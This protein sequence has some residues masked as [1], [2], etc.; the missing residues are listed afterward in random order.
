MA[1]RINFDAA[2]NPEV[3]TIILA[4][5]NGDKIGQLNAKSISISDAMNDASE[6]T[7]KVHKF[8]DGVKCKYWEQIVDFKLIYC[9]EWDMWF[10]ITIDLDESTDIQKTIFAV[11]LGNYELSQ[12]MLYEIE[13]N[14]ENDI[15]RDDYEL[16][17]VFYNTQNPEASLLHRIMEK[18]PH[19]TVIHV[20]ETIKNIQRTFSFDG[21]S[22]YDAF[23]DISKEI[24][25]LFVFNS[26]SDENGK[27]QRTISV[28]DLESNCI[29]C[30][31]RGEY[32]DVCPEC[33]GVNIVEGY[34]EDTTIFITSD[35]LADNIQ[36]TTDSGSVKNCFKLE[37]GD[38]LM[39]A[40]IR[41]CNPNGTDYIWY[42][43][44]SMKDDMSK[45]LV[46]KLNNYDELCEYYRHKYNAVL[47]DSKVNQYN[48]LVSKYEERNNTLK[49]IVAPVTG[50]SS[51]MNVY[52]NIIDFILYLQTSMMPTVTMS[53][54]SAL[55]QSSLLTP[56]NLSPVAVSN[57]TYLSLATAD[58]AVLSMANVV[59]DSRYRVKINNSSI[60]KSSD[61]YIWTGNFT[62]TNYSDDTDTATSETISIIINDNYSNFVKQKINQSLNKDN[63]DDLSISGL[64]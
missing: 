31:Y 24:N 5:K 20:D 11:R 55:E 51:I 37:A 14:T 59:V 25:C 41:N 58:N 36:L 29:D 56:K 45:A 38:D 6:I 23:Q 50:Y 9:V 28:Y 53:N 30:G 49:R 35:E 2:N 46:D 12:I 42:I 44:D 27:I 61:E 17:T 3:P 40:T 39:T 7:F 43:S 4:K 19:Y 62:I 21:T 1:I 33:G 54:T 18:A 47:N 13:I 63:T 16:P 10:S 48:F 60:V 57:I 15:A 34:G 64:C 32:T 8:V 22:I 52:Y 26:N